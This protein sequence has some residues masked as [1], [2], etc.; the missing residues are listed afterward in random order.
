M[1]LVQ[2][3]VILRLRHRQI[4]Q[5]PAVFRARHRRRALPW[6]RLKVQAQATCRVRRPVIRRRLHLR[7]HQAS[8][9]DRVAP[10]LAGHPALR[11]ILRVLVRFRVGAHPTIHPHHRL[12]GRVKVRNQ[13]G[14]PVRSR[15]LLHPVSRARRQATLQAENLPR[16]HQDHQA[17]V[18][19]RPQCQ[20][21]RRV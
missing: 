6:L 1:R 4:H 14:L 2:A 11:L 15:H 19:P 5:V 12:Q 7:I 13:V 21:L 8:A 20:A 9:M 18:V 16:H 3:Q 17:L 10:L